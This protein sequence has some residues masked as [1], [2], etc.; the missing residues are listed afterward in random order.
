MTDKALD[1]FKNYMDAVFQQYREAGFEDGI[2]WSYEGGPESHSP[3]L[4]AWLVENQKQLEAAV[5]EEMDRRGFKRAD[6][7]PNQPNNKGFS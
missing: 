3:R 6:R 2:D 4:M 5:D 7:K 1:P